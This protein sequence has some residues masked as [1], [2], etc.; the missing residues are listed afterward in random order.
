MVNPLFWEISVDPQDL[1][2]FCA[3]QGLWHESEEERQ[4]RYRREDRIRALGWELKDIIE[5]ELTPRQ[6]D[7]IRL[8]FFHGKTQNEI[9]Q[10]MEISRRVVAQH[11]FGICRQGRR[12]GG[13]IQKLQ[14]ACEQRHISL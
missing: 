3:D 9:A 13:A 10:I 8:Y 4:L 1:D 5:H 11:L 6:R 12:I 14:K 2:R 7:I